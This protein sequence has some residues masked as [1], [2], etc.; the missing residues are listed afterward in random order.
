MID[1][2][3]HRRNAEDDLLHAL[4][5]QVLVL[6]SLR[7]ELRGAV[8]WAINPSTTITVYSL[9]PLPIQTLYISRYLAKS[10]FKGN[11]P[12]TLSD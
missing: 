7:L 2:I 8:E 1:A 11:L 3:A 9:L 4:L 5:G 6:K 12:F 10:S